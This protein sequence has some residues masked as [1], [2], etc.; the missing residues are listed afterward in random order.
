MR[1][2]P[3]LL[4]VVLLAILAPHAAAQ[5]PNCARVT[6]S[7]T[8]DPVY[9]P[10]NGGDAALSVVFE[11]AA[12]S[13]PL[14]GGE[15]RLKVSVAAPSGWT[16]RI[17]GQDL[18]VPSGGRTSLTVAVKAPDGA[19]PEERARIVVS[20]T[21][22][23][24]FPGGPATPIALPPLSTEA[25]A[26]VE[27]PA[28]AFGLPADLLPIGGVLLA[29]GVVATGAALVLRRRPGAILA[30]TPE[31]EKAVRPGRGA[32]FPVTLA[33]RG[34]DRDTASCSVGPAPEGWSAFMTTPEVEIGPGETRTLYLMVRAPAGAP[35]GTEAAVRV[36][37]RSRSSPA[38]TQL[39]VKARVV[40]DRGGADEP[41]G[42]A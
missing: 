22:S 29:L 34:R 9:V 10:R 20:A 32:S 4:A 33:N 26:I 3:V 2:S 8:P 14:P 5:A 1:A 7:A 36:A 21:G 18:T 16:A 27:S 42:A 6:V 24:T 17:D 28:P 39:E 41:D 15:A 37:V 19:R 25:T 30:A 13:P 38:E 40:E 23:C 12:P 31:P 35:E 11:N